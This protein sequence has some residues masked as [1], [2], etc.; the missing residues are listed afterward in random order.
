MIDL[1]INPGKTDIRIYSFKLHTPV[2]VYVCTRVYLC[3]N[4][5]G[6]FSRERKDDMK[7]TMR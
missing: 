4:R 3:V 6:A 5:H 1:T 2:C 7:K